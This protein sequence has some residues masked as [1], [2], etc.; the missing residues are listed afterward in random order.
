MRVLFRTFVRFLD[1]VATITTKCPES[2]PAEEVEVH[3][4]FN[5]LP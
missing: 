4:R 1:N 3:D 2:S 5:L